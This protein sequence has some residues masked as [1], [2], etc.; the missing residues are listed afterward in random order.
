MPAHHT[1][2]LVVDFDDTIAITLNRD[3]ENAT[4]NKPLIDKLNFLFDEGWDVHVVTARGQLSCNGDHI[5]ADAKYRVQIEKWLQTHGV[6]YTSLSFQ[7]KLAAYYIDDKGITPEAFVE[8][9]SRVQLKSG[10]SGAKVFYDRVN[11]CVYKTASNTANAVKWFDYA[12]E[13]VTSYL[14]KLPKI[15]TVIGDTIKMEYI[16]FDNAEKRIVIPFIVEIVNRF[17]E[18]LPISFESKD[19][20]VARCASRMKDVLDASTYEQLVGIL[21]EAMAKTENTFGHGDFSYENVLWALEEKDCNVYLIDP[22]YEEG[23]YSSWIIDAAK[24]TITLELAGLRD[25]ADELRHTLDLGFVLRAHELGHLCRM[26]SY[27]NNKLG[28]LT[29]IYHLI[30][31]LRQESYRR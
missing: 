5:A 26:Y 16:P 27:T 9:F 3:W 15:H 28:L 11:S 6:K 13:T 17:A 4:A 24:Y 14:L 29:E 20:Y 12:N 10:L 8:N 7:K 1:N 22:I 23:L 2:T 18:T 31:V 19:S 21:S 25:K 30:H